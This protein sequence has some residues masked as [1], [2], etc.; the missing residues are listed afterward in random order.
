MKLIKINSFIATKENYTILQSVP[1]N[2][3][4]Q[5]IPVTHHFKSGP[6]QYRTRGVYAQKNKNGML[7]VNTTSCQCSKMP[8]AG[9]PEKPASCKTVSYQNNMTGS[10][11]SNILLYLKP[12]SLFF[13]VPDVS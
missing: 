4:S 11:G 6:N 13:R 12:I 1:P 8:N 3:K 7:Y 10:Y 2:F 9:M 5:D